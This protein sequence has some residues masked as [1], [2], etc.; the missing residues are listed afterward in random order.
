VARFPS[1][2]ADLV[3]AKR[4]QL[5]TN[6]A[7]VPLDES[8][9]PSATIPAV[10]SNGAGA[11]ELISVTDMRYSH[12]RPE[13]RTNIAQQRIYTHGAP[14]IQLPILCEGNTD[15]L[16]FFEERIRD[17]A[18]SLELAVYTWLFR[19]TNALGEQVDFR[20]RG[21]LTN[22]AVEKAR[23]EQAEFVRVTGVIR[24]ID[25]SPAVDVVG[26]PMLES[27]SVSEDRLVLTLRFSEAI[28]PT[29]VTTSDISLSPSASFTTDSED[30]RVDGRTIT[31][32]FSRALTS[33]T[34]YQVTVTGVEDLQGT[35]ISTT[36]NRRSFVA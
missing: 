2:Y 35:A 17:D 14:D 11:D 3:T 22:F 12:D 27:A 33:R 34:T 29:T 19:V 7:A 36:A 21:K 13:T 10:S 32:K 6:T 31:A 18:T 5:Y 1:S 23:G 25:A 8:L 4:I 9:D 20:F 16:Q 26:T 28:N 15:M 30:L 24:V